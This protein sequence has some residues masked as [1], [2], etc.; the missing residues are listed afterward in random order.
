[1][2]K[3]EHHRGSKREACTGGRSLYRK[4]TIEPI[5]STHT[6]NCWEFNYRESNFVT[7]G[8]CPRGSTVFGFY[9][10]M[11]NVIYS[12]GIMRNHQAMGL[13]GLPGGLLGTARICSLPGHIWVPTEPIAQP[14]ARRATYWEH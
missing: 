11:M 4:K 9:E 10:V 6:T 12:A 5:P 7:S 1:M 8:S 13:P 2:Y 14:G 3:F